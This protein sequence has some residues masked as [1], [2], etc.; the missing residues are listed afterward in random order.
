MKRFVLM[1]YVQ[2][3]FY[4]NSGTSVQSL[5]RFCKVYEVLTCPIAVGYGYG[6][7]CA[8]TD[9]RICECVLLVWWTSDLLFIT[10]I[11]SGSMQQFSLMF[12][13]VDPG[14]LS[15]Q[16]CPQRRERVEGGL[17]EQAEETPWD[18]RRNTTTRE[19]T[20]PWTFGHLSHTHT[21]T[22]ICHQEKP[23]VLTA[24]LWLLSWI[25]SRHHWH[26]QFL[27]TIRTRKNTTEHMV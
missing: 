25:T 1:F 11:L 2:W 19:P 9:V 26:N 15:R 13:S 24:I 5:V 12:I 17:E 20:T 8:C 4:F 16:Q 18:Y 23:K 27:R 21:D 22:S 10:P 7:A 6:Y 14:H 3:N